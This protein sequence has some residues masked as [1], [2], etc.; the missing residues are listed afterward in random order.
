MSSLP[1]ESLTAASQWFSLL[2]SDEAKPEDFDAWRRWKAS[3]LSNQQAWQ[4]V[5]ALTRQIENL[6]PHIKSETFTKPS[7]IGRRDAIK[8]LVAL[9]SVGTASVL[10]YEY[11]PW[12]E[13]LADEVTAT[14]EIRKTTLADGTLVY[15]NT[16]TALSVHFTKQQ[17]LVELLKGEVFII[18]AHEKSVGYRPFKVATQHGIVTALGTQFNVRDY[19]AHS[20][21]GVIEGAVNVTL[22]EANGAD[23]TL[24][25]GQSVTF[26]QQIINPVLNEEI[27]SAW[28]K[29]LLV[30]YSMPLGDFVAELSRYRKGVLRCDLAV[31][32]LLVSGSFFT[33]D[34]NQVLE[35]LA[36]ILPVRIHMLTPYWVTIQAI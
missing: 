36:Q 18:T 19:G 17:R 14:G 29:G 35:A 34:T 1:K 25:A 31:S 32:H 8:H 23:I 2:S 21:V 20:K 13:M 24:Q 22:N 9:L 11:K 28:T 12:N 15:L 33:A 7:T 26:N 30:V 6:P 10:A 5:E 3:N 27:S 4:R 16:G